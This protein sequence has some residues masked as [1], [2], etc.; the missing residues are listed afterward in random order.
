LVEDT[1]VEVDEPEADDV[2][3]DDEVLFIL[4]KRIAELSALALE[5][6]REAEYEAI[7]RAVLAKRVRELEMAA[8]AWVI[9]KAILEAAIAE[10]V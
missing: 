7:Q 2:S 5:K 3:D 1:N 10:Q 9:E 8:E 6:T 4:E